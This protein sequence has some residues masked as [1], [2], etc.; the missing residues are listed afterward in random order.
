MCDGWPANGW[1]WRP[2]SR[3]WAEPVAW[4]ASVHAGEV[5]GRHVGA[6]VRGMAVA[7]VMGGEHARAGYWSGEMGSYLGEGT[8]GEDAVTRE[9]ATRHGGRRWSKRKG[10]EDEFDGM[11]ERAM[12]GGESLRYRGRCGQSEGVRAMGWVAW[13]RVSNGP[14]N[15]AEGRDDVG[16]RGRGRG[17][18]SHQQAGFTASTV[19]D[20]DEL[21]A[22]LGHGEG[23]M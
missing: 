17:N 15:G 2:M 11:E 16:G 6:D 3:R 23:W 20:D 21:S 1:P 19:A 8:L 22:D 18:N 9:S 7:A 12:T 14:D 10:D 13:V 5:R 4:R